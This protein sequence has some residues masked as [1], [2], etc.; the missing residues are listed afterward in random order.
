MGH[1]PDRK[2]RKRRRDRE[3]AP[4][5][6]D[7]LR[8]ESA[9]APERKRREDAEKAAERRAQ[10]AERLY[11]ECRAAAK[12]ASAAGERSAI[13][14]TGFTPGY[15]SAE[16]ERML[17]DVMKKLRDVDKLSVR[18]DTTTTSHTSDD[19]GKDFTREHVVFAITW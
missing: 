13:S 5:F 7:Q 15:V 8:Q 11:E 9:A 16:D 14:G 12:A 6:A 19:T 3:A 4:S 2:A 1:R 18:L 10:W 17:T